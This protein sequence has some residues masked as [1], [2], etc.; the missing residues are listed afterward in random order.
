MEKY[1]LLGNIWILIDYDIEKLILK[2][3]ND[4]QDWDINNISVTEIILNKR[5]IIRNQISDKKRI[6]NE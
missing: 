1:S 4:R 5:P 6:N 2:M 3:M